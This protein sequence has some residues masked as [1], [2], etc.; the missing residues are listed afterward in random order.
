MVRAAA[1]VALVGT[2]GSLTGCGL[3]DG[4]PDPPPAPDPLAPLIGGALDLAAR[5]EATIAAFPELADRLRPLAE[6]HR[7]HAA[8][9]ARV[10]RTTLPSATVAPSTSAGDSG[11]V[12]AAATL[13]QLR[14]AEQQ[15]R[16]A[17][18]KVCTE[19]PA[20]RA[21]LVGSITA[22]RASHLEVLR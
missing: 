18:A 21:A 6:A 12:T 3:F 8:E 11:A 5:Y 13:K 14:E 15:G 16:D 7:A 4:E 1:L 10:T 19:A 20:D 22:A 2:T 17:A 9:L